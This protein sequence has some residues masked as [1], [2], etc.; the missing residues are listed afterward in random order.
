MDTALLRAKRRMMVGACA[1][2]WAFPMVAAAQTEIAQDSNAAEAMMPN[3]I[4]VTAQRRSERLQDVPVAITALEAS[5]L[6]RFNIQGTKDLPLLTPGLNFPQ[7][8]Y[9]PQPTIRGI[10]LR[11][12]GSGDESV[13]PIY[14]DGVYQPF[15]AAADL[16]F[17]NVER[18][19]VLKGPQ[20][21]LLG[22][23]AT[24]GAINIITHTPTDGARG[25]F[26]VSYGRFNQLIARAYGAVGNEAVGADIALLSSRDDGYITDIANGETYGDT[27]DLSVRGKLRFTPS[28]KFGIIFSAAHTNSRA[29]TGE[30][31]RPLNGN[32][33]GARVPGNTFGVQPFDAALT[34][35]PFNNLEV[36]SLA[37]TITADLGAV[38]LTSITGYQ[39]SKL[40]IFADS[41]GTA[42]NIAAIAFDQLSNNWYHE[43]YLTSAM[44]G[45]FSFITGLVYYQSDDQTLDFVN[46]SRTVSATGVLGAPSFLRLKGAGQT[47]SFAGYFQGTYQFSEKFS[48][49]AGGRY[50][51]ENRDASVTVGTG[52]AITN[53]ATFKKFTPTVTLQFRPNSDL[54]IYA[55]YGEAFKAGIFNLTATSAAALAPVRPESVQ[56]WEI[57]LKSQLAR[58]L[59]FNI[60]AYYTDYADLQSPARNAIGQSFLQNAGSAQIYGGE[61]E[62]SWRPNNRVTLF[63]GLALLHGEYRNFPN[64]QVAIPATTGDTVAGAATACRENPGARVGGNRTV[65][66]D[67]TGK[68]I[69][70]TPF[71]QANA[72][73]DY[74]IPVGDGEVGLNGRATY[75][76]HQYWDTFNIFREPSRVM[77]GGEIS[78]KPGASN[79]MFALWGDNLFNEVY[80]LTQVISGP[81]TNQ[82]LGRPRTFGVRVSAEF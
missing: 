65:I 6:E 32:T 7:S 31:Y 13:V 15:I 59:T 19:E 42:A 16:Q 53:K 77:A 78:W 35:R 45:P 47:E 75:L 46:Q 23:N 49:T 18:I 27:L 62:L 33:I 50:T 25:K 11:G 71:V 21:A 69:I 80:S 73:F 48:L 68:S 28:E 63:A 39:D 8:V 54:N 56:Q 34:Q 74:R 40:D 58:G 38:S 2:A 60:A 41:D 30:A 20:G 57:G 76:G 36:T 12:V 43:T 1:L 5:T 44:D 10:G 66:C 37:A 24:G 81:A 9:S 17:N 3:G 82:V 67:V 4:I 61:A 52:A 55:K 70:R 22:R 64:S 29:S 14:I 51:H 72:G 26:N 79:L